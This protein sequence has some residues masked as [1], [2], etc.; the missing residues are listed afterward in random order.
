MESASGPLVQLRD[1]R[2]SFDQKEVLRGVSLDLRE[3]TTLAVMGGSGAGKTVLLRI[4]AGLVRPDAGQV[5]LFGTR[6]ERMREEALLAVRKRTG[7]VFQGAALFDSLSVFENVA[8]PLREH[9]RMS[10]GEI[11]DRV[12]RFLTLVGMPDTDELLPAELS[13]GMRRR[14]GI[15]RALIMEPE[16]VFFDEPTAGLDPTNARLVAELIA[17]L[18]T[19]VCRTAIVVT[20]DIEFANMVADQMAILHHGRFADVGTPAE[21]RASASPDVRRF[22]AGELRED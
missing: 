7:F 6:I 2:K 16:V 11:T 22:L 13:G 8:Y 21:I 17:T 1:V 20:H 12:H 19:G 3:G 14:V 5:S 15:A 4:A 10:L 9:T 18:R